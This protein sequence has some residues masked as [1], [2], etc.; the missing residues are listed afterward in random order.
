M[1]LCLRGA[2]CICYCSGYQK[3]FFGPA[4]SSPG[5][6][7]TASP[8]QS[9]AGGVKFQIYNNICVF[10]ISWNTRCASAQPVEHQLLQE[11]CFVGAGYSHPPGEDLKLP[12]L[13]TGSTLLTNT[14]R[15]EA[16][17]SWSDLHRSYGKIIGV[18]QI[19]VLCI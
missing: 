3:H 12:K 11:H 14:S 17:A 5:A 2:T 7:S 18:E 19:S 10:L 16:A 15:P 6:M 4:W 8:W 9:P 13:I 1:W